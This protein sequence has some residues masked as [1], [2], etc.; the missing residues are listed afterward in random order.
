MKI[1]EY[2]IL[3]LES[4]LDESI[5][6]EKEL[7]ALLM[8]DPNNDLVRGIVMPEYL[9]REGSI[10]YTSKECTIDDSILSDIRKFNA[11]DLKEF[12]IGEVNIGD[13]KLWFDFNGLKV[14]PYHAY[15]LEGQDIF[16]SKDDMNEIRKWNAPAV[17]VAS[18]DAKDKFRMKPPFIAGY[19]SEERNYLGRNEEKMLPYEK[20]LARG[21]HTSLCLISVNF[22]KVP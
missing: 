20:V 17:I 3:H 16:P 22:E 10:N 19:I 15:P 21:E 2:I 5:S 7:M 6:R 9:K 1:R 13:K 14:I 11:G 12:Y 18:K 4:I 8:Y